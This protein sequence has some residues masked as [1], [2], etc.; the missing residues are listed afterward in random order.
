MGF[1]KAGDTISGQEGRAYATIN[2]QVE[3]MF[4]VKKLEAKVEK[5]KTEVKTLGKR[6][7]QNKTSGWKGSGNMTIYYV[8]SRFREIML[9]YIKNG[10]DTYFDIQIVN[11]DP[12]S[13]I[14][15]Q[16]VVLKNVNLDS[17]IIA[18]IDTD[19]ESMD[20]DTDFTFD[21]VDLLDSF[22]QP[23]LG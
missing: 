3:E 13:T 11:E 7:I 18:K 22:T 14:G 5:N 21:D 15:K 6:G 16:T 8:T 4:Y 20:E 19:S 2:G 23:T 9:E 17:V 1:L 12:T 10:K